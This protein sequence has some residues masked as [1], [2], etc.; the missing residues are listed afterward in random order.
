[1][2]LRRVPQVLSRASASSFTP[3][4][5]NQSKEPT[6]EVKQ[7]KSEVSIP[8]TTRVKKFLL[9]RRVSSG[10][11]DPDKR[12]PLSFSYPNRRGI[13]DWHPTMS[14]EEMKDAMGPYVKE[15][16]KVTFNNG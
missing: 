4:N 1:M 8:L 14:V 5:P 3:Y 6:P 2:L 7:E 16:Y 13:P 10:F 12:E 9:T 11:Y 15:N